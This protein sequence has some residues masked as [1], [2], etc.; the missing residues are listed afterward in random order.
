MSLGMAI[1]RGNHVMAWM[2]SNQIELM[3][4]AFVVGGLL[5]IHFAPV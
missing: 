2:T 1:R 4:G 3:W 5:L